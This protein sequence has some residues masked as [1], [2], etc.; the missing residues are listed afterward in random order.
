MR[1]M[2]SLLVGLGLVAPLASCGSGTTTLQVVTGAAVKTTAGRTARVAETVVITPG[3]SSAATPPPFVANGAMDFAARRARLSIT[4]L[5][6]DVTVIVDGTTI[7]ENVP[8]L[9]GQLGGKPWLKID[10]NEIGQAA[11]I[12]GLG[13]LAQ[14][15]S[16][17]PSQ[18]L[19]YLRGVSGAITTVGHESV[20]GTA[21]THYRAVVDLTK[22]A[23]SSSPDVQ[24]TIQQ[25]GKVLGA[26]TFP[27]DVWIDSAGR[28]RRQHQVFDYSH[29]SFPNIPTSA[30]PKSADITVEYFDFGVAVSAPLPPADQVTDLSQILG[31]GGS[32]QASNVLPAAASL[33][34]RLLSALPVVY[35]QQPGTSAVDLAK[36]ALQDG[37]A[38][39][40]GVL[41]GDGFVG[42]SQ[43][44]WKSSSGGVI[45]DLVYEFASPAGATSYFMRLSSKDTAGATPFAVSGV[46]GAKGFL[47]PRG[48]KQGAAVFLTR[49]RFL[50]EIVIG[51][52]DATVTFSSGLAQD[53]YNLVA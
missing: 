37:K 36:A 44:Q 53:Q 5:G 45:V 6:Q 39:A 49:G 52:T 15:Q 13:N 26:T 51:G 20:R 31:R 24:K 1:R 19:S 16:S 2:I 32:S 48:S 28:V 11:G 47:S 22:A 18:F 14:A 10:L 35:A 25:L 9:T 40:R 41:A 34:S 29:A 23:G 33:Q 7:Y 30:L 17:D 21:T 3:S 50:S 27:I 42:G 46:P 8:L 12:N 38:D 4:V 43:R